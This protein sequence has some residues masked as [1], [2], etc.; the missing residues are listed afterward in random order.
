M[1]KCLSPAHASQGRGVSGVS[2]DHQVQNHVR[3]W[4]EGGH[5]QDGS[6]PV[7]DIPWTNSIVELDQGCTLVAG[8][9]DPIGLSSAC[10]GTGF[11]VTLRSAESVSRGALVGC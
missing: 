1:I 6:C 9:S 7:W 4:D 11:C 2:V 8:G 10:C 5:K 3:V